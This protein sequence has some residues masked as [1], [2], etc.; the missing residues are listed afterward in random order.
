MSRYTDLNPGDI[1][2]TPYETDPHTNLSSITPSKK[3]IIIRYQL[4]SVI[5]DNLDYSDPAFPNPGDDLGTPQ[6]GTGRKKAYLLTPLFI[7]GKRRKSQSE[8]AE[9]L[10]TAVNKPKEKNDEDVPK[11]KIALFMR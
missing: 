10:D 2:I 5:F 3:R 6:N 8:H 11:T 9:N 1:D 4:A 7:L